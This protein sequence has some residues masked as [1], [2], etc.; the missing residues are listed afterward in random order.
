M[1]PD[2]AAM[3]QD[4]FDEVVGIG[5]SGRSDKRRRMLRPALNRKGIPRQLLHPSFQL[6]HGIALPPIGGQVDSNGNDYNEPHPRD[7][8]ADYC[9]QM[10]Y[11]SGETGEPSVETT[12]IIE[13]IVRQQVI[14][15]VSF[16]SGEPA[17]TK[18]T[19]GPSSGVAPNWP[20]DADRAP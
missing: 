10:M 4:A 17:R 13:D 9:H 1:Q 6:A 18:L 3:F 7:I 15:I 20:R 16:P 5:G 11:V 12:G 2:A 19:Y 14:E 8:I